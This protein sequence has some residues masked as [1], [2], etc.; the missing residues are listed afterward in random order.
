MKKGVALFLYSMC[1]EDKGHRHYIVPLYAQSYHPEECSSI[2]MPG[3]LQENV[4][5]SEDEP[6]S[7]V[8]GGRRSVIQ[9]VTS[10]SMESATSG[11]SW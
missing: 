3:R 8:G 6:R 4:Q 11:R 7:C 5:A 1:P 9:L 2:V 10:F